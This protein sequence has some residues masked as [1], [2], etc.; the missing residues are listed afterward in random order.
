M[1][2]LHSS[3]YV[4]R[5]VIKSTKDFCPEPPKNHPWGAYTAPKQLISHKILKYK[6]KQLKAGI[7]A[8]RYPANCMRVKSH[9]QGGLKPLMNCP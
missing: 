4:L 5:H 3:R 8:H 7:E 2:D 1:I 6:D 9:G